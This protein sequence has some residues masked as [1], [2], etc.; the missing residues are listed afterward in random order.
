LENTWASQRYSKSAAA[1]IPIVFQHGDDQI[2]TVGGWPSYLRIA[3]R[4]ATL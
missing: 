2:A 4:A 3:K 1:T